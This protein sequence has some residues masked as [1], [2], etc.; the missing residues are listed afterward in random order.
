MSPLNHMNIITNIF[1]VSL[2]GLTA[3]GGRRAETR[4]A[5]AES[6]PEAP[7]AGDVARA[8]ELLQRI[9]VI[10]ASASAGFALNGKRHGI[11]LFI[12]AAVLGAHKKYHSEASELFFMSPERTAMNQVDEVVDANPTLV[13]GVDYLFWLGYGIVKNEDERLALLE[14]G[15][16]NLEKIKCALVISEYPDMSPAIGKMLMAKQ[17]PAKETFVKLN[18]RVR[19][20]AAKHENVILIS[21]PEFL[22]GLRGG[23]DFSMRGNH[24][25]KGSTKQLLQSDELHPT[26]EG[27]AVLTVIIFDAIC[28]IRKDVPESSFEWNAKKILEKVKSVVYGPKGQP[29]EPGESAESKP[30]SRPVK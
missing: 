1:I 17:V 16:T 6:R 9:H 8:P 20:W 11:I 27:T 13:I 30:A 29:A 28:K 7:G 18:K 5:A 2:L 26:P 25:E 3:T 10:G 14:K 24:Y 12:D 4:P 21:L 23:T 15:L 22:D 19:E